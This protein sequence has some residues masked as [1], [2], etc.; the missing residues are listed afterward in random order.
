[1]TDIKKFDVCGSQGSELSVRFTKGGSDTKPPIN[2]SPSST[3][4]DVKK[5]I[6]PVSD[7]RE[8]FDAK[9]SRQEESIEEPILETI[10]CEHGNELFA[11]SGDTPKDIL[12]TPNSCIVFIK[13]NGGI[14]ISIL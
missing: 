1:M 11:K 13:E 3:P 9:P 7:L 6:E 4:S 8:L 2:D 10:A 5:I 12:E 14:N